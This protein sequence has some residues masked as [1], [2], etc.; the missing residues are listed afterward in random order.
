MINL[1]QLK[2]IILKLNGLKEH[3]LA[4]NLKKE[5]I[6]EALLEQIK[7]YSKIFQIK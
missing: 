2:I 6:K 7:K 3:G 1:K 4:I 5:K